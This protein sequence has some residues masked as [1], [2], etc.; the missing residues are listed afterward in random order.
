[1]TSTKRPRVAAIG[2]SDVQIASIEPL[3]GE[4][5][6]A[7]SLSEYLLSYSWAETDV[8]VAGGFFDTEVKSSVNLMTIGRI[9]F[10]WLDRYGLPGGGWALHAATTNKPNTERE[11][12]VPPSCP[13]LYRPQAVELSRHLG[14]SVEPS[15]VIST[16]WQGGAALIETTS[17]LPVAL[18]LDFPSRLNFSDGEP[19][20]HI[21]LLLPEASNLV[22]WFRAFLSE[23]HESDPIG[24][25]QAPPRLSQP[26]DWYTPQERNLAARI[27]QIKSEIERLSDEQ[28]QLQTELVAEGE[29]ADRGIRRALWA[30][31]DELVAAIRDILTALGFAVRDMD[32]ELSQGESRR[33]D[34]RLT[35][36]GYPG[37]E[38]MVEVKGYTSGTR[39]NDARQIREHRE[40][41]IRE[42]SRTPDLTVWLSNPYRTTE[43]S[44][45]PAPDQNVKDAAETVGALH[46]LASDI[47]R[48]WALVGA[49][50]LEASAVVQ[51]LVN[52]DPGLWIPT[53]PSSGT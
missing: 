46:V 2:L 31:G 7:G 19:S 14:R 28:V 15:A 44:S 52:A 10:Q 9:S 39:T 32:E 51:S 5:R 48:Q 41:Y 47:Y 43:P 42:E 11:L 20:G 40:R 53:S 45:R 34:L 35:L 24:V 26:S 25:P 50:I 6:P 16:S 13:D 4:L 3:C 36:Q 8:M 18:R 49:G 29:R 12:T 23:L 1:M 38:A 27:S 30:D 22:A 37:W 33:E 21:A 17:G